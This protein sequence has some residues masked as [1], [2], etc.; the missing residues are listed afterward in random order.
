MVLPQVPA[1]PPA[2]PVST[3]NS[4]TYA[5]DP[6]NLIP[7]TAPPAPEPVAMSQYLSQNFANQQCVDE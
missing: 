4:G 7:L 1:V 2:D 3:L 6:T 5:N